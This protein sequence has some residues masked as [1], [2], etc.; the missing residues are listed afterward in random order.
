MAATT[1][2]LVRA[3]SFLDLMRNAR[4]LLERCG[5]AAPELGSAEDYV[6]GGCAPAFVFLWLPALGP[7][8]DVVA[9]K[10]SGGALAA[11]AEVELEVAELAWRDVRPALLP[12]YKQLSCCHVHP[13]PCFP[14]FL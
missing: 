11:G 2:A 8:W 9:A 6:A 1:P 10:I 12:A 14:R 7:L 4:D 5:V 3:G 13:S